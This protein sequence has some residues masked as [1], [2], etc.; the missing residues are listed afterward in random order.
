[1]TTTWAESLPTMTAEQLA[2]V[3][4]Q[5]DKRGL[6]LAQRTTFS[7]EDPQPNIAPADILG[8]LIRAAR[9]ASKSV[10]WGYNDLEVDDEKKFTE[11]I[12][13]DTDAEIAATYRV[14]QSTW[15][16]SLKL[17]N[18]DL[19]D[20]SKDACKGGRL[21]QFVRCAYFNENGGEVGD[22]EIALRCIRAELAKLEVGA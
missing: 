18:G 14:A 21:G 10:N 16:E 8:A 20:H 5:L 7:V 9:N 3:G 2:E 12:D 6:K 22:T 19:A 11:W 4:A 1:M 17:E 15:T 13:G